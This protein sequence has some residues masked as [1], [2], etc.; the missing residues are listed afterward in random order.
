MAF[1]TVNRL[2]TSNTTPTVT[3]TVSLERFD[4]DGKPKH[5]IEVYAN[6][7]IYTLFDGNLG[8]DESVTPNVWK[9][10]FN[11]PLAAGS[12]SINAVVRNISDGAI[13]AT[14]NTTNELSIN[15][16]TQLQIRQQSLTIPQKL[17]LVAGLLNGLSKSFGGQ[18]G[19]GG[20]PA[21]HPTQD[22]DSSTT[23]VG[24]GSEEGENDARRAS[25][26]KVAEKNKVSTPPQ[27]HP[28][29]SVSPVPVGADDSDVPDD[30]EAPN[31]VG[32]LT[33]M[34]EVEAAHSAVRGAPDEAA[35]LS[36]QQY[37]STPTS[38]FG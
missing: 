9:L 4:S 32:I 1:I 30:M 6:Y 5:T 33:Q 16:P 24:R 7:G 22:D 14:D 12:Y 11:Q 3:G 29:A 18:S 20:N 25:N 38:S 21:V 34:G 35:A 8:L 13:V 31:S 19:M 23:L 2:S 28:M 10:R 27:N 15:A 26:K 36:S 17:A 37:S